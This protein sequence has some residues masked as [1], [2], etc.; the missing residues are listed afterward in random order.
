MYEFSPQLN[1]ERARSQYRELLADARRE[2][3]SRTYKPS[4]K[5]RLARRFYT[6]ADKLEPQGQQ[7]STRFVR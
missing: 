7:A 2:R 4:L 3:S 5:Q 6:L 1:G